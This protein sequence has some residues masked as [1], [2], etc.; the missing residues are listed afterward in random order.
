MLGNAD[1]NRHG[2]FIFV[3]AKV[4]NT[5]RKFLMVALNPNVEL[6]GSLRILGPMPYFKLPRAGKVCFGD[7]VV[8]NSDARNSNTS[9]TSR[10]K[11]V[12]G[13]TGTIRVGKNTM[14]NGTCVVA[15]E[16]VTI[17]DNCQFASSTL[18]TDTDF[19]PVDPDERLKQAAGHGISF[20]SVKKAAVVIGDNVWIGW[21]CTILKGVVIGKNSIV[22]AGSVVLAGDYPADS[23]IA[24]NP[25]RV[26][27][28]LRDA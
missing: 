2:S 14:F 20:D 12:T 24:G 9:L 15:Y 23:I 13:Y 16:T 6:A 4:L 21:N 11:F 18:V 17:G 27:K 25:A 1:D 3:L 8:L 26:V 28:K 19:H 10:C 5:I 7:N 22:G